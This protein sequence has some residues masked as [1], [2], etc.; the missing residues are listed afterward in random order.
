M[1]QVIS[2]VRELYETVNAS[3]RSQHARSFIKITE[4]GGAGAREE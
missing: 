3:G 4:V 2:K 1:Q